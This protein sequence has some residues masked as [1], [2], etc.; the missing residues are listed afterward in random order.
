MLKRHTHRMLL[1]TSFSPILQRNLQI[2]IAKKYWKLLALPLLEVPERQEQRSGGR[3]QEQRSGGRPQRSTTRIASYCAPLFRPSS[4][5]ISKLSARKSIGSS[6]PS[7]S[8]R[9]R[10]GRSIARV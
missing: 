2:I 1:C 9:C 7:L 5:G 4:T 3:S 8:W 6:L 10:N